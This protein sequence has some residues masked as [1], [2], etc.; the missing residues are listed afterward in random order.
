MPSGHVT[1]RMA[2]EC[3][4][5]RRKVRRRISDYTW[6]RRDQPLGG[7]PRC[8]ESDNHKEK[9]RDNGTMNETLQPLG[10]CHRCYPYLLAN[11]P[12]RTYVD[13]RLLENC[14]VQLAFRSFTASGQGIWTPY[15]EVCPCT[16]HGRGW[17][18]TGKCPRVNKHRFG[19][20]IGNAGAETL[21]Q[22]W[23]C[24]GTLAISLPVSV[25]ESE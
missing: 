5:R 8:N 17:C 2:G 1:A 24:P 11:L 9:R 16:A 3:D 21:A 18:P 15:D 7:D 20:S 22:L 12:L 6:L 14:P 10:R 19:P 4:G 23:P 13:H 25:N